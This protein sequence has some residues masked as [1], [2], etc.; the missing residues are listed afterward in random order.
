MGRITVSLNFMPAFYHRHLG[1]RYG[2]AYYF[3][4]ACRAD[5]ERAEGRFLYEAFGG[6][7]VGSPEPEPS[8]SFFMQ[9]VDLLMHTQGAPWQ[10]PEDATVESL[11]APWAGL[12]SDEVARLDAR[13]AAHHPVMDRILAQFRTLQR[14]YGD[15]ADILFSRSGSMYTHTPYTSAHQLCGQDLFVDM[16]LEPEASQR[17]FAKVWEIY[18]ALYARIAAATGATFTGLLLGDCAAALLSPET[19]RQVV[20]P[21]N[22]DLAS[23]FARVTYH[24]CGS[25][26]HLLP[27]FAEIPHVVQAQLGPGTDLAAAA[28]LLPGLEMAP[29]VDAVLMRNGNAEAVREAILQILKDTASAPTVTLCAWSFDRDTPLANVHALYGAVAEYERRHVRAGS[30]P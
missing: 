4:P 6:H 11:A 23:R 18:A 24:S 8:P 14:L 25:S 16:L 7:G 1:L 9:P 10:F 2:E 20:L 17:L 21:T 3:D 13:E 30:A 27:H 29:L 19:Y 15:Q 5:I 26:T 22:R 12:T 28:R